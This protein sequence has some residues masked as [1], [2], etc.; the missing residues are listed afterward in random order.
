MITKKLTTIEK[1]RKCTNN[2]LIPRSRT[3]GILFDLGLRTGKKN[4]FCEAGQTILSTKAV[5]FN[6]ESTC[7]NEIKRLDFFAKK[8]WLRKKSVFL[9]LQFNT[10][11]W[12]V[13]SGSYI[14]Y[15][16]SQKVAFISEVESKKLL[17]SQKVNIGVDYLQD[18]E[19][20]GFQLVFQVLHL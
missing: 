8:N 12:P 7:T 11:M 13:S 14:C 18:T 9:I 2:I 1:R 6:P 10:S 20:N 17:N 15:I 16:W 5:V 4:M 3:A 19:K